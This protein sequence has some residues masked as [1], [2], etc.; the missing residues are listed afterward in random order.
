LDC[1]IED[2][3][4]DRAAAIGGYAIERLRELQARHAIIGDVRGLGLLIG[5]ELTA[6]RGLR[7]RASAEAEWI[8]YRA[9][10]KGLSFKITMGNILTLTPPL[11]VA[12]SQVDDAIAILDA[13]FADLASR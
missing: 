1:L 3:L 12:P 4:I 6:N 7:S 11:T 8:M 13:C 2:G 10:E 5:V 9:L